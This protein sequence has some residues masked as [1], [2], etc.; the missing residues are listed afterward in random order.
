[1]GKAKNE[2]QELFTKRL[3]IGITNLAFRNNNFLVGVAQFS[4]KGHPEAIFCICNY[5]ALQFPL[6]KITPK[7]SVVLVLGVDEL[8]N[9]V[10][11]RGFVGKMKH[12]ALFL[13]W[14]LLFPSKI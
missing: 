10:L 8:L 4:R 11:A 6:Q 12:N 14:V 7:E 9:D 5:I 3:L 13:I 1:M 2:L